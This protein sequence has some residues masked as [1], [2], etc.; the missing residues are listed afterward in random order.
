MQSNKAIWLAVA[1]VL[2]AMVTI[3]SGASIA[4]Q[5][6]PLIGPAGTTALR[7]GFSA[8]MLWLVFRPWRQLPQGRN[9]RAV[10]V[11]GAC[12][13]GMNLLFYLAIARIPLGIGVALEF[14]GPLAVALFTSRRKLDLIWVALALGGILL[15]LPDMTSVDALDP[16]G[17]MLALAAGACWAGYILFGQ[18]AGNL[19]SGG[20]TVALGM[21]VA[22]A[23][24]VPIGLVSAGSSLFSWQVI[25]LAIAVAALSSA[26]P[27]S[28]E[29]V[30]LKALPAKSFSVLM[31]ME[32]A[33]AALAG[34]LLLAELLSVTQWLAILLVI[35]A[36][37]GSTLSKT[38]ES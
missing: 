2:L 1:S 38:K 35:S 5:L 36:S 22:A 25:P 33:I 20:I 29:M 6:F 23:F 12:L 14:T 15:L 26:L 30:A 9:W 19:A 11:Y 4:K 10:I 34:F 3:Q 8:L 13:G 16:V 28:L 31:S 17:V 18:R 21:T 27:Y 7:V 24:L 32:P 37:L